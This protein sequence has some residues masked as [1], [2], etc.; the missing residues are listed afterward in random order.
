M[1]AACLSSGFRAVSDDDYSRVT[2]AARFAAAPSADPS[3][4]SWLP[5]PFWLYGVPMA[6]FGDSLATARVVAVLLGIASAVLVWLAARWLGLPE[7]AAL[8][9]ALGAVVLPYGS[10]L[11]AATV[12]EAPTAALILLGA[13]SLSRDE[14]KLRVWGALALGAACFC[15]YEAWAPAVVFAVLSA[16]EGFSRRERGLWLGAAAAVA[17]IALWLM[18]GVVRHGDALFF[19]ARVTQYR[20]AL[21]REAMP[22]SGALLQ[23][24]WALLRFEPELMAVASV[25]LAVTFWRRRSP[26][27][28]TAWRTVA[29]LAALVAFLVLADVTGGAATHHPERSLLPVYWFLALLTAGL[30]TRLA[31]EPRAW[32][33]PALALPLAAFGSVFVRPSVEPSFVDRREEERVGSLLRRLGATAIALDTEDFGYFAIQAALGYG[34]SAALSDR[35]PRHAAAKTPTTP[36]ELAARLAPLHARWL[37]LPRERA[38]LAEP[39]GQRRATTTRFAVVELRPPAAY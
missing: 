38:A 6:L 13:V 27:G 36:T 33:L 9:G 12:P 8:L 18:H 30:V 15:R 23:T 31:R 26:F 2:I 3:G 24:P 34:K 5:L 28:P 22:L 35:D 7:R 1:S 17:P 11:S 16:R 32:L 39:L 10:W 29:A 20:A 4:T 19:V 37:V 14:V 25:A 21:G